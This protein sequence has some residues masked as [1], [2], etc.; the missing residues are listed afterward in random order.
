MVAAVSSWARRL[1]AF[2]RLTY[3]R[4]HVLKTP[5]T[6][7][8]HGRAASLEDPYRQPRA[9]ARD[10]DA[11]LRLRSDLVGG[12]GQAAGL[13]D[14]DLRVRLGRGRPRLLRLCLGPQAAAGGRRRRPGLFALQPS[15]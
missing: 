5:V 15:Q 11:G 10:P 3:P 12:R 6:G 1:P 2:G 13:P 14:L 8:A 7:V 9:E 4:A